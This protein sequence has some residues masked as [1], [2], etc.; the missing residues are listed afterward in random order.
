MITIDT[1]ITNIILK[2]TGVGVTPIELKMVNADL[3]YD[4]SYYLGD[5]TWKRIASRVIKESGYILQYLP[6]SEGQ[7]FVDYVNLINP[8]EENA[9]H[10]EPGTR[11]TEYFTPILDPRSPEAQE[12]MFLLEKE[13][14]M[15][16]KRKLKSKNF[17]D[18]NKYDN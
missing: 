17:F 9:Y 11:P 1:I 15:E 10:V 16:R 14:Y 3:G 13:L 8:N 12:F 6:R 4:D 2:H 18:K 5:D 7:H